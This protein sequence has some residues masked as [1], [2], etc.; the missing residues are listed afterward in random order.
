MMKTYKLLKYQDKGKGTMEFKSEVPDF[1]KNKT[2]N[3]FTGQF[4]E[5]KKFNWNQSQRHQMK[6]NVTQKKKKRDKQKENKANLNL[7]IW[8]SISSFLN[9]L[10]KDIIAYTHD[11]CIWI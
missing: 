3:T 1:K 4:I 11:S 6:K 8:F 9:R 10:V 7:S 2:C 5:G